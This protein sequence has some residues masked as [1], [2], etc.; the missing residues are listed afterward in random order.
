VVDKQV[1]GTFVLRVPLVKSQTTWSA[2]LPLGSWKKRQSYRAD[3]V[4]QS[5]ISVSLYARPSLYIQRK[6]LRGEQWGLL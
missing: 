4:F 5:D 3:G 2:D 1:Y 6:G